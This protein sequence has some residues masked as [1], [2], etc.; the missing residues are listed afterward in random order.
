[1]FTAAAADVYAVAGAPGQETLSRRPRYLPQYPRPATSTMRSR[2]PGISAAMRLARAGGVARSSAPTATSVGPV[3]APISGSTEGRS[4]TPST[5]F[6]HGSP[7]RSVR[8]AGAY[9]QVQTRRY[10]T[11]RVTG[12]LAELTG[13]PPMADSTLLLAGLLTMVK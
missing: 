13:G 9:W 12:A 4:A 6:P 11:P 3:T 8:R 1:M 2:A 5:A 7:A 10:L